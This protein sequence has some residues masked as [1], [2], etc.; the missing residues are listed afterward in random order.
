MLEYNSLLGE[1]IMKNV[2]NIEEKNKYTENLKINYCN[3]MGELNEKI[4]NNRQKE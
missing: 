2:D 4:N 3:F 1:K